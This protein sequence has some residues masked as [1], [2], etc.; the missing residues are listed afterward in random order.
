MS[1]GFTKDYEKDADVDDYCGDGGDDD[2]DE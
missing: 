2:D 1:C